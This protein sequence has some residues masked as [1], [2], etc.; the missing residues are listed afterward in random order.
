MPPTAPGRAPANRL[1][2]E[3]SPYLL[4][5]AHN[6]V[7]WYPWGE[8]ALERARRENRLILLSIGYS[9]CHWCHV[10][11]RESFESPR[12]AA[13]MNEHCVNIKVDREERP[14]LDEIYMA[15]AMALNEG[16]GGWPM[17]VFLTPELEPVFAGTYFPPED[18]W[19]RPGFG[20][21]IQAL[22]RAWE[23]DPEDLRQGAAQLVA[24]LRRQ[25]EGATPL[26]VG[27]E[28][29]RRALQQLAQDFDPAHGGF[30]GAPKFPP[31]T[32][33]MLLLR[34]H[35]RYGDEQALHMVRRTLEAMARGGI[36]DQVGGGFARYATDQRWLVPH[37][38]KMLY[39]NAL[40]ASAYL[41][42]F[43]LTAEPLFRRVAS[44]TL[45][46]V[47]REMTAP[48]GGFYSS[49][50]ADSEGEEGKFFVW[51]PQ[52]V[53][54][55][56]GP[57]DARLF[58]ACY[59]ITPGGNWE[60]K[61]I[62]HLPVDLAELAARFDLT[63]A[64]LA[65]RLAGAREQLYHARRQRV[66]PGLDD[67]VLTAWN[68]MMI[69]ALACGA[70]VLAEPRYLE[71]A[72][73]AAEFLLT[74]LSSE[75]GRLLRTWRAGKAHLPAYLEDYAFLTEALVDLYEASGEASH[76]HHAERLAAHLLA[77]FQDP[78]SGAFFHTAH[79]HEALILRYRDGVD[80]AT[81][82]GNAVAATA[83]IRLSYHLDR[84]DLR[85]AGVAAVKAYG[86]LIRR[87]PRAFAKT[88]CAV[89]LLL[90]GPV[91]LA[92][93]GA[94][95]SADLAAL[96]QEVARCYLPNRVLARVDPTGPSGAGTLPLAAGKTLELDPS[97]IEA[98]RGNNDNKKLCVMNV[99]MGGML[100]Q[101]GYSDTTLSGCPWILRF[102]LVITKIAF[103]PNLRPISRL[104]VRTLGLFSSVISSSR[105]NTN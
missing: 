11:E 6:P 19:G 102:R 51:T 5:H 64:A 81:P 38:E 46:Y 36:Y 17:T 43:Q 53:E 62:P 31:A 29:L 77:D 66:P 42:A 24:E 1:A 68:G 63:P 73:R 56:L 59:D 75:D 23:E 45:G 35:H 34:L 100:R 74:T 28:E 18:R 86:Q 99:L 10:M 21:L 79:H 44:E 92:L 95:G 85:Q 58:N 27:E 97:R 70:Q 15:A 22:A 78:A 89:D 52:Q 93:A 88:L 72:R 20:S 48:E 60:G 41:E 12:I 65:T 94:A 13:L 104:I 2:H 3:T 54:A 16:Q 55:V 47:L 14:D 105:S 98:W 103:L 39:D 37:F 90:D 67:K 84:A 61:S 96:E 30:G 33:L 25:R 26:A 49:T 71:A 76:L 80:G 9:A 57:E 40:L 50:D 91:E 8:E 83:L 4:Q 7:D 69:R 101:F 32:A 87:F 82:S